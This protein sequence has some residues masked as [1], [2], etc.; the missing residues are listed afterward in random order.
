M[1]HRWIKIF[2]ATF[3]LVL[4]YRQVAFAQT[5]TGAISG[6]VNDSSGA[7]VPGATATLTNNATGQVRVTSTDTSGVFHSQHPT[8]SVHAGCGEGGIYRQ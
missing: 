5:D 1:N 4:V 7:V 3:L 8:R 2:L 6:I